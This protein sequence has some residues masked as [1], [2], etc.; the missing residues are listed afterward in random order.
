MA[1]TFLLENILPSGQAIM[2]GSIAVLLAG[3]AVSKFSFFSVVKEMMRGRVEQKM[4]VELQSAVF[5]RILNLPVQFFK[6]VFSKVECSE[7]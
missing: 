1:T 6:D 2:V 5:A 4:K 7:R 3:T